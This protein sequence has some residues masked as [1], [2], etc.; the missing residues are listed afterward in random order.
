MNMDNIEKLRQTGTDQRTRF[1][2]ASALLPFKAASPVA[3]GAPPS[4]SEPGHASAS[5][6]QAK[7]P[8]V[9]RETYTLT[10]AD[11]DLVK[12]LQARA[13][14]HGRLRAKS[15]IVRAALRSLAKLDEVQMIAAVDAVERV[16]QG[17]HSRRKS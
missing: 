14:R 5:S 3:T 6:D 10:P 15:E 1:Q 16:E 2:Q 17:N 7:A 4:Q 12:T 11:R 13:G 8:A 9:V